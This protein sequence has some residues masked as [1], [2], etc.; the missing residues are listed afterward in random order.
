[1]QY[2]EAKPN[3]CQ[4]CGSATNSTKLSPQVEVNVEEEVIEPL[5]EE[6][7]SFSASK[8]DFE[9][10]SAPITK[11]TVGELGQQAPRNTQNN[12][13][14]EP[15]AKK[16]SKKEFLKNFQKEAGTSRRSQ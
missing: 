6:G 11:F 3:F 12:P 8:L 10:E 13:S 15:K 4:K 2:T 16:V 5:A 1:M 9:I 14:P 7:A